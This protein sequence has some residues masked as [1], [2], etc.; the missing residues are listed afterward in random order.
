MN[1]K[2]A[3]ESYQRLSVENAPPLQVVRMLYQGALRFLAQAEQLK[4]ETQRTE[5]QQAL[6]DA[7]A[8]ISELRNSLDHDAGPEVAEQLDKLYDFCEAQLAK[9]T[10]EN[11]T[12]PISSVSQVLR[13]LLEAW[14]QIEVAT[15]TLNDAG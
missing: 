1:T 14:N 12:E 3:A 2:S 10:L 4:P 15:P 6:T 11:S 7:D 5:F 9:A 8:I 13:T